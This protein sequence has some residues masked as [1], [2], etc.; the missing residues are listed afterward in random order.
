MPFPRPKTA[1]EAKQRLDEIP[2]D[3]LENLTGVQKVIHY[4]KKGE[5]AAM[6][7]A[8]MA[9]WSE[10][11]GSDEEKAK[12]AEARRQA[13]Q[14]NTQS[15]TQEGLGALQEDVETPGGEG[16]D[17]TEEGADEEAAEAAD[18]SIELPEASDIVLIGDSIMKGMRS[19]FPKSGRPDFIGETGNSSMKTL[20]TLRS[21]QDRLAGKKKALI[22]TGGNNVGYS[23]AE[24][25]VK[26]MIEMAEICEKAGIPEIVVC[27]R[28]PNDPRRKTK[29]TEKS[30]ALREH[31]LKAHKEGRFPGSVKIVDLYAHF[32]DDKGELQERY[33]QKKSKDHIHPRGAYKSALNL[34]LSEEEEQMVA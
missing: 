34:M 3:E 2:P 32:A 6:V 18:E 23:P 28:F 22:Y 8:I 16:E 1:A 4:L 19:K 12:V 31:L 29:M 14:E 20:E 26:D 25:I 11:F 13:E 15:Q 27:T 30:T 24:N 17:E 33:V 10:Y 21:Q 7:G 5:W 9:L